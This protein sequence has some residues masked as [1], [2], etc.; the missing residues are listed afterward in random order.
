MSK[1]VR[2]LKPN[3]L[4]GYFADL[5]SHPRPSKKEAK[6]AA[7]LV[8]FGK[9]LGY[10]TFQDTVGNVIIKR[11]G[12]KG[13]K[14]KP[15]ILQGHIDMVAQKNSDTKF[16]FN[17]MGINMYVDKG[18]VKAKGTTL[19]ADNGIGVAAIMA[20]LAD[21]KKKYPP[22][23]AVFTID[24][25]T[26]MTGAE[27]LEGGLF[28]GKVMLNLDSED[29]TEITIGCAGGVD[30]TIQNE[31]K[32]EK[33]PKKLKTASFE[34]AIKGLKGGH[35]G[36][37]IHKGRGNANKLMARVLLELEKEVA[38]KLN[39]LEGGSLRNAI[40]R[41]AFATIIIAVSKVERFQK[42]FE[43]ISK[44]IEAEYQVTDPTIKITFEKKRRPA[45]FMKPATK[46]VL[47]NALNACLSGIYRMSPDIEGLVQTS[48]N[49]S[50]IVA[51]GGKI[52][53]DCLTRSSVESEK[54]ACAEMIKSSFSSL[55]GAVTF[56][57]DYPGWAPEPNAK[58][59]KTVSKVY[60][61]HYKRMPHITACHAGLECGILKKQY[62]DVEMISFGPN[63]RGAHSPD[64][65]VE[66][67]S[68]AQFYKLLQDVLLN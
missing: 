14:K 67:A 29:D 2:N 58:I 63:I 66:V 55:E 62:P 36:M 28:K 64:E 43:R 57:G 15:I 48:N 6:A 46:T 50:K 42:S 41:E 7:F 39:A 40:P 33:L 19:G 32:E 22:L 4:W 51:K 1:A 53:I 9:D 49:L 17:T 35:S 3:A 52:K 25:E 61:K 5:N 60:K 21:K 44:T 8:K 37:D 24:E 45:K 13:S 34:I 16:D 18:W 59:I 65:R 30:V 26:G 47:L 31:Y 38:L 12:S 27:M 23:E 56:S 68:V 10:E 11:P 54:M 20:V